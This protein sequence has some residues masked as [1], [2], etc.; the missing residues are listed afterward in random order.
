MVMCLEC[1]KELQTIKH[2]HLRFK[3]TGALANMQ[4]YKL[5]YPGAE[6]TNFEVRQ[7]V[8]IT[9][10]NLKSKYGEEEGERRWAQYREKQA[11]TNSFEHFQQTRGWTRELFVE[12]N[13][14][15][16]VT[17][18]NLIIKYGKEEGTKAFDSYCKKQRTNGNTL[19]YFVQKYGEEVGTKHFKEVCK[20]KGLTLD[21]FIRKY[22]EETGIIKYHQQIEARIGNFV[23][24]VA[25][26]FVIGVVDLIP[27]H[28][29]FHDGVYGKE[30]CVYKDRPYFYDFAVTYPF[31]A[32]VEFN[33]DYWHANPEMFEAEQLIQYPGQFLKAKD[34][35]ERDAKKLSHIKERGYAV[36]T[37]WEKC[38]NTNKEQK[39]I[40]VLEWLKSLENV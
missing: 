39:L 12:Y 2:T 17:L 13:K 18:D 27:D 1:G 32:C 29:V 3:C 23:S 34:I 38:Y 30:F 8:A 11:S 40:E 28:W 15:R 24:T 10:D 35:W 7:K 33:G 26:E 14:S 37:V 22:G 20:Q 5:K 16:G 9:A 25:K 36:F 6:T 4:E 31:H 21:N 19:E